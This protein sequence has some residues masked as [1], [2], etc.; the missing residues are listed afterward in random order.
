MIRKPA[1]DALRLRVGTIKSVQELLQNKNKI[2]ADSTIFVIS[3][4]IVAEVSIFQ[5]LSL[6]FSSLGST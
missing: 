2:Y 4:L 6:H 5:R 3:H 1:Q